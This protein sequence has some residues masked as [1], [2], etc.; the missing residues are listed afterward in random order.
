MHTTSAY[1]VGDPAPCPYILRDIPATLLHG[2]ETFQRVGDWRYAAALVAW[3]TLVYAP[4]L[5]M[6][7]R[8]VHWLAFWV[9]FGV[10]PVVQT[11][12]NTAVLR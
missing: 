4:L 8:C 11:I 12:F 1:P 2:G 6:R 3:V 10:R 9:G 7:S 5:L